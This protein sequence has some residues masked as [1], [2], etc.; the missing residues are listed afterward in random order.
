M[1]L[2]VLRQGIA[3]DFETFPEYMAQLR[4]RGAR[5]TSPLTSAT[6]S[7]RT[8]VM[9]SDAS[10]RVATDAEIAQMQTIVRDAMQAGAVGFASSTSPA[11]NGEGGLPMPSR[12]A[13]DREMR[14]AGHGDERVRSRGLHADQRRTHVGAVP[15]I[16]GSRQR[17]TGND[18]C[19]AAQQHQSASR[20]RRP[21]R[22]CRR[23]RA[24]PSAHRPGVVLPADDGLHDA[25][26]VS[27]RGSL[28]LETRARSARSMRWSPCLAVRRF[29]TASE[30]SW[31]RRPRFAS[32]T[33]SGTKCKSWKLRSPAHARHEQH[34]IADIARTTRA[35]IRST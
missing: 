27:G 12:L 10:R 31:Q 23:Q 14:G 25:V 28:E 19:A 30:P 16:A 9:G 11:H 21:R 15:R 26:T 22:D 3:W 33:A 4:R 7:V 24:R 1:S 35:V 18:R 17:P 8:Y 20:V 2:D 34:T 13:D 6:V 5:S 32:S 29:A